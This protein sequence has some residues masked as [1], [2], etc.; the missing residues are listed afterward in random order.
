M[1]LTRSN[2][3]FLL[4]RA[5]AESKIAHERVDVGGEMNSF[6]WKKDF[7]QLLACRNCL[8]ISGRFADQDGTIVLA[9][10]WPWYEDELLEIKMSREA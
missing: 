8:N 5:I 3:E 9:S 4:R 7:V 6:G 1:S 2:P 10:E